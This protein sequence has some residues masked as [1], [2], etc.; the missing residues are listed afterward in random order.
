[1]EVAI[2]VPV[3][4]FTPCDTDMMKDVG[5]SECPSQL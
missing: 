3:C 5:G 4:T 2:R 1:M